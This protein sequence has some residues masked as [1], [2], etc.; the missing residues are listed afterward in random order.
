[1]KVRKTFSGVAVLVPLFM[2]ISLSLL[3]FVGFNPTISWLDLTTSGAYSG[4]NR[5]VGLSSYPTE[6][7][8]SVCDLRIRNYDLTQNVDW[9]ECYVR[10]TKARMNSKL[11]LASYEIS[12]AIGAILAKEQKVHGQIQYTHQLQFRRYNK[13]LVSCELEQCEIYRETGNY[14]SA[15]RTSI[16][17]LKQIEHAIYHQGVSDKLLLQKGKLIN[18]MAS[19]K[20]QQAKYGKETIELINNAE[21][22]LKRCTGMLHPERGTLFHN[23]AMVEHYR[24]NYKAAIRLYLLAMSVRQQSLGENSSITAESYGDLGLL[25][26]EQN[27]LKRG[28]PLVKKAIEIYSN[29]RGVS[30]PWT[31]WYCDQLGYLMLKTGRFDEAVVFLRKSKNGRIQSLGI[32]HKL[33]RRT[34]NMLNTAIHWS[35]KLKKKSIQK[36]A[37]L[38]T[39]NE[40]SAK[41]KPLIKVAQMKRIP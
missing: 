5:L 27:N 9:T 7:R 29:E 39:C 24:K 14:E 36:K 28:M 25:F 1:M 26:I 8:S 11:D 12:R 21:Q 20:L 32:N 4:I 15:L 6:N 35:L 22:V 33:T 19:I 37:V 34:S 17:I 18:N 40:K 31:S 23:K 16:H 13:A 2:F 30:H 3:S 41:D 10:A 38:K